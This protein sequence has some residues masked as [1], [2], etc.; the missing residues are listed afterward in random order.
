MKI[1]RALNLVV[2][3]DRDDGSTIYIHAMPIS[4]EV[5]D[6]HYKIIARA[7]AEMWALGFGPTT[8]PRIAAKELRDAAKMLGREQ[9]YQKL[10]NEI[11]RLA[12]AIV[13]TDMGYEAKPLYAALQ[14]DFI[15]KE[16][17]AEVEN[18]L[19]FFIVLSAMQPRKTLPELLKDTA[20]LWEGQII[21][22]SATEFA[23]SLKTSTVAESSGETVAG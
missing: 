12:S 6:E 3:V 11:V 8:G 19:S 1:S 4:A 21:S 15:S 14:A 20:A 5:F 17:Y 9:D 18:I 23:S 22:L 13:P 10:T 16:D 2:P 7:S